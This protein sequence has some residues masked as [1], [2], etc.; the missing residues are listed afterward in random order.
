MCHC[1]SAGKAV[2]LRL[3]GPG[4]LGTNPPH[5]DERHHSLTQPSSANNNTTEGF[6][7]RRWFAGIDGNPP[8]WVEAT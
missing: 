2:I 4:A 1:F 8:S 7:V 3:I 6:I 5:E